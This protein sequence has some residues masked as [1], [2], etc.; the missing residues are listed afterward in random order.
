MN[1]TRMY[2]KKSQV[3]AKQWLEHNDHPAVRPY[4]SVRPTGRVLC[5]I[6]GEDLKT[7][8]FLSKGA[9]NGFVVCPG[10]FIITDHKGHNSVQKPNDFLEVYE[11]IEPVTGG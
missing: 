5:S 9:G 2:R 10:D 4:E 7:H 3:A 8:G 1:Q 11:P 6:C